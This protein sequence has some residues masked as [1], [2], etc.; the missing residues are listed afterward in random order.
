MKI[1]IL[2]NKAVVTECHSF[3]SLG[4]IAGRFTGKVLCYHWNNTKILLP[5]IT[6]CILG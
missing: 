3:V 2:N 1:V 4:Y 6:T 5:V